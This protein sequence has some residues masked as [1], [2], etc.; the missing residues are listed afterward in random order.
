MHLKSRTLV[1]YV[2]CM[3]SFVCTLFFQDILTSCITWLTA[4]GVN[5]LLFFSFSI[6]FA[7]RQPWTRHSS[8]CTIFATPPSPSSPLASST[9]T[10]SPSS[11][12]RST[13]RCTTSCTFDQLDKLACFTSFL[14]TQHP[15]LYQPGQL[16][17]F[18]NYKEF[19]VS[20]VQGF[21][22]SMLLFLLPMGKFSLDYF[23]N[24]CP[25]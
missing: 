5:N 18:F 10:S 21:V 6:V 20:A 24:L 3:A 1:R 8:Q 23:V 7:C 22:T 2:F 4:D 14:C 17:L 11:L 15:K 12:S 13:T 9:R 19:A 25:P 16:S